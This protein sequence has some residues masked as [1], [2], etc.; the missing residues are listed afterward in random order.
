[1]LNELT[2]MALQGPIIRINPFELHVETPQFYEELYT[3]SNKRR[4]KYR[5]HNK[6]AAND[7]SAWSTVDHDLH[8]LRRGVMNPFFS[9]ASVRR[10]QPVIKERVDKLMSRIKE[11]EDTGTPLTISLAYVSLSS[12]VYMVSSGLFSFLLSLPL[13]TSMTKR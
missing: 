3:G 7:C 9:K 13:L 8:R 2:S 6:W 10:L 1:M 5:W 11:L 4:N 12:G